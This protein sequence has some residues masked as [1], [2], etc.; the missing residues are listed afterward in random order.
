MDFIT[1]KYKDRNPKFIDWLIKQTERDDLI[2]D[3]AL[4]TKRSIE[5]GSLSKT[6]TFAN[7]WEYIDEH[8]NKYNFFIQHT[9]ADPDGKRQAVEKQMGL[10]LPDSYANSV[11]PLL[12]LQLAWDEYESFTSRKKFVLKT[13]KNGNKS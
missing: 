1:D 9:D 4:D 2:G 7:I 3:V 13:K 10:K 8:F 6:S 11:S 5:Q 12:C